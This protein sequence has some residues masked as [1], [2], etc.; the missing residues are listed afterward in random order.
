MVASGL[1]LTAMTAML[2]TTYAGLR[3]IWIG[4]AAGLSFVAVALVANV[5]LHGPKT[6][7]PLR[8]DASRESQHLP[9][10]LSIES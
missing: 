10:V 1:M 4:Y 8:Y 6:A 7:K 9:H 2:Y 3:G 5:L